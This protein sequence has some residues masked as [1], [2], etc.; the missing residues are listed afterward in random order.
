M[1]HE[2]IVHEGSGG[3]KDH[4]EVF[5]DLVSFPVFK[6]CKERIWVILKLF[7]VATL[8]SFDCIIGHIFVTW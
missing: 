3:M 2:E 4:R 8:Y 5:L 7:L 1:V 6:S